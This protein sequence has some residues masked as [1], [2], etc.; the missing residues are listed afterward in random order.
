MHCYIVPIHAPWLIE[1]T[2]T[3]PYYTGTVCADEYP[4]ANRAQLYRALIHKDSMTWEKADVPSANKTPPTS[5][6][7]PT[8]PGQYD[9]AECRCTH[10]QCTP[11]SPLMES[12]ATEMYYGMTV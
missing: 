3:E 11:Q 9:I 6:H 4:S 7:S 2:C 8:T 12:S 10:C 5:V 1:P